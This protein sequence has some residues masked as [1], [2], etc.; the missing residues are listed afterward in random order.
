MAVIMPKTGQALRSKGWPRID[1]D[2]KKAPER[3][4]PLRHTDGDEL[5]AQDVMQLLAND[6]TAVRP[7]GTKAISEQQQ[8]SKNQYSRGAWAPVY[9]HGGRS[10]QHALGKGSWNTAGLT[11]Q[12]REKLASSFVAWPDSGN[13]TLRKFSGFTHGYTKTP[14]TAR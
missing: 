14:H 1:Y 5:A 8:V 12:P 2:S 13:P 4:L 7:Q 10:S 3:L 11:S 6:P 9:S